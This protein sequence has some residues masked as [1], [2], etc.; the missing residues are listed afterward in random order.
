LA[1]HPSLSL[2]VAATSRRAANRRHR[3][4]NAKYLHLAES[5]NLEFLPL[6]FEISGAMH[7]ETLS[8]FASLAKTVSEQKKIPQSVLFRF[9][10][11]SLSISLQ[12]NIAQAINDKASH[13]LSGKSVS[14]PAY[15]E[16][17]AFVRDSEYVS[18]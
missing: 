2:K 12:R 9:F 13:I 14:E 4:K 17:D 7:D 1:G 5:S 15:D 16:S 10:M 3:E 8:F 11:K 18:T 6:V